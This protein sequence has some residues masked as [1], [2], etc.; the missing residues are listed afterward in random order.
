MKWFHSELAI[1]ILAM[2]FLFAPAVVAAQE[3]D[4]IVYNKKYEQRIIRFDKF[5]HKLCPNLFTLQ[6]AGDI[7]MLSLG[8]GW[9]YGKSNQWETHLL[10]GY[11]PKRYNYHHYTTLTLRQIYIPWKLRFGHIW[12]I[13]PFF[14]DLSVNSILHSDFWMTEPE[15]YPHGYYGFSSRIRFHL[16]IG[17]RFTVH[18]PRNKRFF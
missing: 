4:T 18:V 17:Q 6:F 9:D 11:L 10:I 8:V 1:V 5:W 2:I 12:Q 3:R 7:G 14:V 13:R 15:R 16:G